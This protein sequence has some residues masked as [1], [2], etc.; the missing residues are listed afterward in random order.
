MGSD[1]DESLAGLHRLVGRIIP[2]LLD[3]PEIERK[4][5][6]NDEKNRNYGEG[7]SRS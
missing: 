3:G 6:D 7:L 5:D 1:T 4:P 2:C